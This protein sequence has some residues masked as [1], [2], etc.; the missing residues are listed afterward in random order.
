MG[1]LPTIAERAEMVGVTDTRPRAALVEVVKSAVAA[2]R[3]V[4]FLPPYRADNSILLSGL[5]GIPITGLAD[6]SSVE[7]I[8][9]VVDQR[10][11]KIRRGS[12]PTRR[13]RQHL[14]GHARGSH[15]DGPAGND[16]S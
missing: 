12:G 11:I 6:A 7:F 10:A 14:G 13:G 1:D 2:G 15:A 9:A 3:E 8:R 16:G 4:R 5:L